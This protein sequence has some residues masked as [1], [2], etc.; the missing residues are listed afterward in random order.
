MFI[1][2]NGFSVSVKDDQS[3]VLFRFVQNSPSYVGRSGDGSSTDVEQ[4][5]VSSIVMSGKLAKGLVSTIQEL[6]EKNNGE[7]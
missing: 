4:E 1:Y 2:A 6:F 3:E 5:I 7:K